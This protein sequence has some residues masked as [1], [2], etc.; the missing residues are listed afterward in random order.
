MAQEAADA[1]LVAKERL[2]KS[3]TREAREAR[4]LQEI[5]GARATLNEHRDM[6]VNLVRDSETQIK[7]LE[8]EIED[9]KA[10]TVK[11]KSEAETNR[12]ASDL[13]VQ[14]ITDLLVATKMQAAEISSE[15]DMLKHHMNLI[16]KKT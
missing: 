3:T 1:E 11:V 8:K 4:Y 2:E 5:E 16:N 15:V 7:D 10:Q 14:E 9:M 13:K 12:R 6:W